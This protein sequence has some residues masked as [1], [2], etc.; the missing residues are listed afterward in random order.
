MRENG[1][2]FIIAPT[3]FTCFISWYIAKYYIYIKYVYIGVQRLHLYIIPQ[4]MGPQ[5]NWAPWE[6]YHSSLKQN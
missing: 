4:K 3:L 2:S 6:L 5:N 1:S